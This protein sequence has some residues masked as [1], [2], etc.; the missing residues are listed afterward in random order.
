MA[1]GVSTITEFS[2]KR[3]LVIGVIEQGF[4]DVSATVKMLEVIR[5]YAPLENLA[6]TLSRT[7]TLG[8]DPL[9][10]FATKLDGVRVLASP[11][12]DEFY[13]SIESFKPDL[14]V[15]FHGVLL[16]C[17]TD[18]ITFVH[19]TKAPI[20]IPAMIFEEYNNNPWAPLRPLVRSYSLGIH[21]EH[22][23]PDPSRYCLGIFQDQKL[24]EYYQDPNSKSSLWRL[25]TYT[26]EWHPNLLQT[27]VGDQSIETF[28]DTSSLYF[29][30]A[31]GNNKQK[32]KIVFIGALVL[33]AK[34]SQKNLVIVVPGI[35]SELKLKFIDFLKKEKFGF[36]DIVSW[37]ETT[38]Q[39]NIK[40]VYDLNEPTNEKKNDRRMKIVSGNFSHHHFIQLMLASEREVL[41]TGDQ[42]LGEALSAGKKIY[43][44][45]LS[46][47]DCLTGSL[48]A[49]IYLKCSAN[50]SFHYANVL[51]G[52]GI[53]EK[54]F[55]IMK[56]HFASIDGRWDRFIEHI[57][58][59]QNC[60]SRI[61]Q[62]VKDFLAA[63]QKRSEE[64]NSLHTA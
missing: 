64:L 44:Q 57:H 27:I 33:L 21:F 3:L 2:E 23:N 43:Y 36:L 31:N 19:S 60:E 35:F 1:A 46:H 18:G 58:R 29:G 25:K 39:I 5:K 50:V 52:A 13:D 32:N 62:L 38:K 48:R 51:K 41:T 8:V 14:V 26:S 55:E 40:K 42:S 20:Q 7:S 61:V 4:G 49:L 22:F 47:K 10:F 16:V 59:K 56:D 6:L 17:G 34:A 9:G 15:L 24:I 53:L 37:D 30:Y 54:R 45:S 28:N 12:T 11:G 63:P